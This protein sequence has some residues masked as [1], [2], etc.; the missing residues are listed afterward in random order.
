MLFTGPKP[1]IN[2]HVSLLTGH[3]DCVRGLAILSSTEFLSCG[4]DATIRRWLVSGECTH[5]YYGHTNYVYSICM[6]PNGEDF[7][8]GGED[9][10]VRVWKNGECVQTI[11][12]PTESIWCVCA[13]PNGDIASGAR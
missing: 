1:C 12:H 5:V 8:S 11:P 6:M 3:E 7:V 2:K 13:L 4:N 10:T 9:R